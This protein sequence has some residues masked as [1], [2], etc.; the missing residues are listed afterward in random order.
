MG[1]FEPP[2]APLHRAGKGAFLV[3]EELGLDEARRQGRTV[4]GDEGPLPATGKVVQPGRGQLLA[5]APLAHQQ[6]W[7]FDG[8]H[9]GEALLKIEKGFGLPQGLH[10]H[11][12]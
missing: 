11:R 3:A 7:P 5:G 8:R 6:D 1:R 10:G 2:L 9:P 12:W 4:Q